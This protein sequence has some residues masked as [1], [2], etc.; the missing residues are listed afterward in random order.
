[1]PS[2]TIALSPVS[3]TPVAV[4]KAGGNEVS[5]PA[6]VAVARW[7]ASLHVGAATKSA[8]PPATVTNS[9]GALG[10]PAMALSAYRNAE[11]MMTESYPACGISWN[12]L[13]GI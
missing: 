6:V 1:M 5:G 13:A 8:P 7:P 9:P 2:P 10:I 3:I 12:L 4:V 11:E